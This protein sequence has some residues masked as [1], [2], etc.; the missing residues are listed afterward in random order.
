MT[1][2]SKDFPEV[3]SGNLIFRPHVTH[4]VGA[5]VETHTHRVPHT[6][7]IV[8]GGYR[9]TKRRPG[10]EPIVVDL[11]AGDHLLV[12]ANEEHRFEALTDLGHFVCVFV[13]LDWFGRPCDAEGAPLEMTY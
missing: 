2:L 3:R 11:R 8:Q 5:T 4:G 13:A 7:F 1:C 10:E 6:T 9:V 12:E